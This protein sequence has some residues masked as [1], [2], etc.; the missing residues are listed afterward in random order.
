MNW[1]EKI[2]LSLISIFLVLLEK[3]F[4]PAL[5]SSSIPVL[6]FCLGIAFISIGKNNP[7]IF[8]AFTGGIFL[9]ILSQGLVGTSSILL[10]TLFLVTNYVKER[11]LDNFILYLM[12]TL[13]FSLLWSEI[14]LSLPG[15][16]FL[17]FT[18][19][20]YLSFLVF[21]YLIKKVYG[22]KYL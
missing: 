12:V 5:F 17:S 9:D 15:N 16:E 13:I 7:G 10:L 18:I 6:V 8:V 20:N 19:Y 21:S 11:L 1:K 4:L 3:S 2:T 14:F 22:S